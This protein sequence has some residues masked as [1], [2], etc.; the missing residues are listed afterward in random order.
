MHRLTEI[1]PMYIVKLNLD[2]LFRSVSFS[3]H[4]SPLYEIITAGIVLGGQA[5]LGLDGTSALKIRLARRV[6]SFRDNLPR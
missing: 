2:D 6:F 4:L 1:N 5:K 3:S